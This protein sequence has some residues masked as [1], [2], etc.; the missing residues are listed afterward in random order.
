MAIVNQFKFFG[1]DNVTSTDAQTMFGTTTNLIK[2]FGNKRVFDMPTA[3]NSMTGIAIGCSL[4]KFR[5]VIT[6]QRVEFSLLSIEQIIG[7][8]LQI[9]KTDLKENDKKKLIADT[10]KKVE[11]DPEIT[12]RYP[13]EF[14]GGQRQ[15]IAIARAI[16]LKPRFL[17]LD[18]PTSALDLSV[19]FQIVELLKKLQKENN[20]GYIFISHDL[21]VVKSL[22][23]KIIVLKNGKIVEKG[24]S[25]NI[26]KTPKQSYTKQLISAAFEI[27]SLN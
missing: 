27:K 13:H 22:A 21:R 2:K 7:E 3:E 6:H 24:N 20:L 26:F 23:H 4:G 1:V 5:P 25:R 8:G 10:L 12:N 16:I 15:R 18:E 9:H 17:L 14:S 19:Q 11:L